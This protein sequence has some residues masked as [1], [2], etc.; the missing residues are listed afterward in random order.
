[1]SSSPTLELTQNRV[2]VAGFLK[3]KLGISKEE[4]T[5]RWIQHAELFKSTELSK[6]ILK[7]DQVRCHDF[8]V[9]QGIRADYMDVDAR[10]R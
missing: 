6:N 9:Q 4:F 2:R 1:M 7:Y 3:R 8:C 10:E 5:R